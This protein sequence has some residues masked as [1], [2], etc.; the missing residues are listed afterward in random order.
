MDTTKKVIGKEV[1]WSV[2]LMLKVA[3][4]NRILSGERW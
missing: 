1:V 2:L 4:K 3:L